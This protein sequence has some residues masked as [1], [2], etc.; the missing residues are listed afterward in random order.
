MTGRVL[1]SV[2]N[3]T[4]SN[5]NAGKMTEVSASY[6][7]GPLT[8]KAAQS[9][10]DGTTLRDDTG[11]ASA[12]NV[13][14][15]AAEQTGLAVTYNAGFATINARTIKTG[16]DGASA[17]EKGTNT[18]FGVS[19]PVAAGLNLV[20]DMQNNSRSTTANGSKKT[21]AGVMKT[22]SKRTTVYALWQSVT[23]NASATTGPFGVTA[24]AG[25]DNTG[26][27]LGIKHSF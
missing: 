7:N 23:N 3:E 22:L 26:V 25:A 24:A 16:G 20:A 2:G 13:A 17:L 4:A 9:T 11:G 27:A 10:I 5:V 12:T 19:V 18:G 8:V 21:T 14:N 15:S 6:V 1:Y